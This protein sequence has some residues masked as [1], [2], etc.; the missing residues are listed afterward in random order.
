MKKS[1]VAVFFLFSLTACI[2]EMRI[3]T[4]NVAQDVCK[5]HDGVS[6][7]KKERFEAAAVY[8]VCQ[9]GTRVTKRPNSV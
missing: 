7:V 5:D 4:I 9:D 1:I 2:D 8:V 6:S 3:E